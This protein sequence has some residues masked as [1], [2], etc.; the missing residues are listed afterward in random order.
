M[1]DRLIKYIFCEMYFIFVLV[2]FLGI[3]M[4]IYEGGVKFLK[5]YH[6]NN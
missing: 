4:F 5:K 1:R 2:L 3:I 6:T